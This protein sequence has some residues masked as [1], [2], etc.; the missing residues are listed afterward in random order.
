MSQPNVYK[1]TYSFLYQSI[2]IYATT[3]ALYLVV[4]ATMA[5]GELIEVFYDPVVYLL[6]LIILLSAGALLYNFFMRRRIEVGTTSL[7]LKSAI[8]TFEI[9]KKD[10]K[11]VRI[12]TERSN[13]IMS[14]SKVITIFLKSRRRPVRILPFNFDR[15]EELFSAIKS[16]AGELASARPQRKRPR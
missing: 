8:R 7:T 15:S 9:E 3:L 14:S 16:W 2:A 11:G 13:R 6:C 1:Y 5:H 4:R 12:R 10:V